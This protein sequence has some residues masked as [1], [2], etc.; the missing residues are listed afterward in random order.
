MNGYRLTRVWKIDNRL[1]VAD[2]VEDAM[3]LMRQ[4]MREYALYQPS[5]IE[6]VRTDYLC[7]NYDAII[8][9]D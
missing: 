7:P 4:Y 9:E 3:A 5:S 8:K 2:S 6:A 1:V